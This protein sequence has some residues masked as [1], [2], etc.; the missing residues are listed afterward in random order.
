MPPD[1]FKIKST[2]DIAKED[3]EKRRKA[4]A[5]NPMLAFWNEIKEA[6]TGDAATSDK[7]WEAM[8]D[9]GLPPTE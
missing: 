7:Y 5:D 2:V 3:E 1:G 6:L 8:K 9:A 4:A